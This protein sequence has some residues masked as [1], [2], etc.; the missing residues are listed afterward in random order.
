[1]YPPLL[2]HVGRVFRLEHVWLAGLGSREGGLVLDFWPTPYQGAASTGLL[3][4]WAPTGDSWP[5]SRFQGG[6]CGPNTHTQWQHSNCHHELWNHT[7][8]EQQYSQ[9]KRT[10]VAQAQENI[11][12]DWPQK[13]DFPSQTC[14]DRKLLLRLQWGINKGFEYKWQKIFQKRCYQLC[15]GWLGFKLPLIFIR[16]PFPKQ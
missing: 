15:L 14:K 10:K 4:V 9:E 7:V 11:R 16:F 2:W 6:V 12:Q 1:M 5:W 3:I 8:T 13:E